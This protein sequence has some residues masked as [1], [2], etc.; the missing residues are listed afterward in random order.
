MGLFH[1]QSPLFEQIYVSENCRR[2]I[3]KTAIL[4]S[5]KYEIEGKGKSVRGITKM[6]VDLSTFCTSPPNIQ[7][8]KHFKKVLPDFGS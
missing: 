3:D 7:R 8:H 6:N 1:F 4:N 2:A 5:F